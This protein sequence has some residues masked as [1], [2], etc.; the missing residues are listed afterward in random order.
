MEQGKGEIAKG[1]HKL[2]S[3]ACPK[4]GVIFLEADSANVMGAIFEAP[5]ASHQGEQA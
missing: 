4:T 2:R 5:M 1:G 3:V